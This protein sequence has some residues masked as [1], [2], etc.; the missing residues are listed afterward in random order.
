MAIWVQI[1]LLQRKEWVWYTKGVQH[2]QNKEVIYETKSNK[3]RF[4]AERKKSPA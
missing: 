4:Q 1:I 3:K 2:E